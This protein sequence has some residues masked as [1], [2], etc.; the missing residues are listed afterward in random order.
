[1]S[2]KARHGVGE[3]LKEIIRSR[4]LTPYAVATSAKL[5]PTTVARWFDGRRAT[6]T[7]DSF[8]AIC[9]ALGLRLMEAAKGR[10]R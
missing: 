6:I 2:G 7:L 5:A 9:E 10:R 4:G 1:M 3:Q 8:E